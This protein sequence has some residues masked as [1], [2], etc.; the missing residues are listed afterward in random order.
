MADT[1]DVLA[2]EEGKAA[3]NVTGEQQEREL[4]SYITAVSRRLDALVGPI[5]QRE[6]EDE[7]HD[8]GRRLIF[9][10]QTPVVSITALSEWSYT[11]EQALAA[12]TNAA[13]TSNDYVLVNRGHNVQVLRRAGGGD[14]VFTTGRGN[15][16][17]TYVAG[18]YEDTESV[19]PLFK[20]A[21]AMLLT[22][23]WRREQ[24]GGTRTFG[25]GEQD[26]PNPTFLVPNAVLELLADE[27]RPPAIR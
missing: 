3:V 6:V 26:L 13:K 12:E 19:D 23:V 5:V 20:Q 14:S 17:I 16:A 9:P 4:E 27:L 2:L 24:G 18:R 10:R 8:G 15:V 22:H 11:T 7:I 1:L 25:A 21:A